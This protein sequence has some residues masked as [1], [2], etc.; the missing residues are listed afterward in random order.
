MATYV[1]KNLEGYGVWGHSESD[2]PERPS[3]YSLKTE[4]LQA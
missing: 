1:Q 3:T 2:T 4:I